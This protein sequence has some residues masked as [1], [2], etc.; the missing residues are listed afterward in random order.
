M[1]RL[2]IDLTSFATTRSGLARLGDE[3]RATDGMLGELRNGLAAAQRS[4]SDA[5]SGIEQRI[6][7][8]QGQR[9]A[10]VERQRRLNQDFDALADRVA[11]GRDPALLVG[12]LDG[13]QP[14]ALLPVRLETRYLT[15]NDQRTLAIRIYPDDLHTVDHEPTPTVAEL[16]AAQAIWRARYRRDDADAGRLLRDL[17]AAQGRGRAHWLVR[18]TTP[19]NALAAQDAAPEP[20]FPPSETIDSLAKTTRA[21]LLPE[22]FCAIGYAAGRREVFRVW[23]ATVPDELVLTPDWQATD[24]PEAL[25]AGDRAW[26]VDFDAALA[27]GM[28][29]EVTAQHLTSRFDLASGTLERL[30]VTGFEWTKSADDSA[31]DFAS[32][33]AAQRDSTGLDFAAPGTPTNNTEVASAGYRTS[34]QKRTSA[35]AAGGDALQLLTWAF[36]L[37]PEALAAGNI[38]NA[39]L[40]DQ[41]TAL[42]MMNLLWR[43]TFAEYLLQLWNP[44][45]ENFEHVLDTSTLYELRRYAVAY[46]RPAGALPLLRVRHQPYGLLPLVGRRYRSSGDLEVENV[47]G[48]VL[49]VLRPLWEIAAGQVPRLVDGDLQKAQEILQT[50]AWSQTAFYRDKDISFCR[51]PSPFSDA[52]T[53]G[54]TEVVRAVLAVLGPWKEWQVHIGVCNDFLPDPPY[55]AGS[56]A[57]VP[58]VLAD[59]QDP[60][61][62]AAPTTMLPDGET[63][64]L[65]QL[66]KW[67]VQAPDAVRST[68]DAAQNGPELLRALSAYSVQKEQGDAADRFLVGSAALKNV[69][70]RA[71]TAMP[72][73][74]ALPQNEAFFTVHTPKELQALRIPALTGQATLGEHVAN[75]A[76][77]A[78]PAAPTAA[79]AH[80]AAVTLFDDVAMMGKATRD[81]GAVKLSLDFL[82]TR[83]VGELN[84][85][86]RSTLDT[87]SYRLDA[88]IAALAN[89]RLEQLRQARPR[90]LHIGAYA[91]V[92]NLKADTRPDSEGFLLAPSQGQAATAALLRSAFMANHEHGAF[93]IALDSQRTRRAEGL[94]QGLARDQPLAALYGYRIER[95]LRDS[96]C[97]RLIWPLRLAYPWRPGST[98]A[99]NDAMESVGA[100]DVVDGVALLAAWE[101]DR[102]VVF[103]TLN[104][105]LAALT[106]AGALLSPDDQLQLTRA[107]DAAAD[108]AD[109]VSDLLLAEGMHQIVQ[110]QPA[111]AAAAMAVADKQALPIEPQFGRTPRGGASYTQRLVAVCPSAAA[112]WP[113]DRRAAA[114]PGLNA[115]LA[116]QLGAAE[117]YVFSALV[118]RSGVDGKESI[119]ADAVTVNA[120]ELGL[121]PLSLVL[122]V[123]GEA[124]PR[125]SGRADTG[126]RGAVAAALIARIEQ[127]ANV[128]GLDIQPESAGGIGFAPFEAFATAL[129]A[130]VDKVRYATRKDLVRVDTAIEAT[131][132]KEGEYAGVDVAEIVGRADAAMNAFIAAKANLLAAA[133]ADALLAA[134]E[135]MTDLLPPVA[136]PAQVFAIN[137][138]G[139]DPA[140]R[141]E[142]AAAAKTALALQ[143]DALQAELEAPAPLLEG[144]PG[145]TPPQ[146]AQHAI[147]RL[148]RL[149][150]KDFPVLPRFALGPYAVEFNASLADQTALTMDDAWRANGWLTQVARVREGADR[151]AATLSAHEALVAPLAEGDLRVL[152]FPHRAGQAWAALPEFWR[153]AD[154]TPFNPKS[155]PEEL[156][157]YLAQRPGAPYRD[158]HRVAPNLAIA[159]HAPGLQAPAADETMAAF[160][161][162]DW[163]E[164]IPDP[165]QTAAIAFHYDAPGA[166]PPQSVLLALPPQA[167]QEAWSFDDALDVIHEAFDLARLRAVRPRDL[168]SGLGAILPASYLPQNYTDELPSVRLLELRREALAKRLKT[169]MGVNRAFPLGKI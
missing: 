129:K 136:W 160:V 44:M 28:A 69:V 140:T 128:S 54:R 82:A 151:F 113:Q 24:N 138:A 51:A 60:L 42:H 6:A 98:P 58:W 63:N 164:F 49:G 121:S 30:V 29:I 66:A 59:T 120:G 74:E 45:K 139:A 67:S 37:E 131:L 39:D 117:A 104:S 56:L 4:N 112:G 73:V 26:M 166:R 142:R 22:R 48:R 134:L 83:T 77:A 18:V 1:P 78:L 163:P 3:L 88:W 33:L 158:I 5:A 8:A 57:G 96:Q 143:L 110:G 100:R 89:R 145:P 68:L 11:A 46:L 99:T 16:Q 76:A 2:D 137:A 38:A 75:A 159:L 32:L 150:G 50:A 141:D 19:T 93:D 165:F 53:S 84:I 144:Q 118:H 17:T 162:D 52:Q 62:E 13:H 31:A 169:E 70:S 124:A 20:E 87:F 91:W 122:L 147:T 161:C 34:D 148:K 25:L 9:Q 36:G 108:L 40:T 146:N 114:E 80:V 27:K 105:R 10:L 90:G 35:P 95:S 125:T 107:L 123:H 116:A 109:S 149:F 81:L 21:V 155:V 61:R 153:E 92:E 119:D 64:Y 12:S 115:W 94:L 101:A 15:R 127:P 55:S 85:A 152:Q 167:A 130:L 102:A 106:S 43:G 103:N 97:G 23:G 14:I 65:R 79:A 154:G 132:P 111:R 72:H 126:L 135:A 86:L 168:G 157:T 7:A 71:W 47:L 156:Q 133:A 41:R